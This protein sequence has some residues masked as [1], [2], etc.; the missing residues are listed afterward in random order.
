MSPEIIFNKVDLPEPFGPNNE[1]TSFFLI[2]SET[3]LKICKS[4]IE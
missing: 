1:R 2:V 4:L 3:S